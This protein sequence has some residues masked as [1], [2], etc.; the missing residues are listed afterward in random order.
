MKYQI[1]S[2]NEWVY[3]DSEITNAANKAVL[4]S[5]RNEDVCFQ[6]L[7]DC[8]LKGGEGFAFSVQGLGCD[9]RI[10]QMLPAVANRNSSSTNFTTL[11][12]ESVKDIVTRQAP[13]EVYDMTRP[14][15]DGKLW[16]GRGAFYVQLRVEMNAAPCVYEGDIVLTI[17]EES[18]NIPVSHKIYEVQVPELKDSAFHMQ[19][20]FWSEH[21]MAGHH[22][23]KR[24]TSEYW[25]AV[26]AYF[27]N[28]L[29][30]RNDHLILPI[31]DV[32][33]DESGKVIDF[34]LSFAE[35]FGKL[36]LERGF[37][38]IVGFFAVANGDGINPVRKLF[39]DHSIPGNSIE[40]I[41]QLKLYFRRIKEMIEK[42]NWQKCYMQALADEPWGKES[43]Y[44]CELCGFFRREVPGIK[45]FE[46]VETVDIVGA[47]DIWIVHSSVYEKYLEKFQQLQETGEVM[48]QYMC[49]FPAGKWM[50]RC[51]DLPLP[52][53][54]LHSWLCYHYRCPG[55]L[56][57]GFDRHTDQIEKN[58]CLPSGD[59]TYLPGGSYV[60]Y[61]ARNGDLKPWNSVRWFLQ[62][63]STC[64]YEL[65][66]IL[67]ERESF[68]VAD[69][70]AAKLV[71]SF[72]DYETSAQRVDEVRHELLEMLK[73]KCNENF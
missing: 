2:E 11:D 32:V 46:A 58:T 55:Y 45:V 63:Q 16:E 38:Y 7:T 70:M 37:K 12:Y 18:V 21:Y 67:G 36:G 17:G 42:N 62:R 24:G 22:N 51:L 6:I 52:A 29:D 71:R 4:Y 10:Y 30:M 53:S 15:E 56:Y 20:W 13:F 73:G 48:W 3:P 9:V 19:N 66:H 65:L 43:A 33:Y 69:S 68:E 39:W 41:R 34:D 49:D 40:G 5:A 27:D 31:P 26:K 25:Q 1:F 44:Y 61:P 28:L 54:R 72:T 50:K 57:Y 60:V 35:E 59:K 14:I 47:V 23:V 8:Q 64:D